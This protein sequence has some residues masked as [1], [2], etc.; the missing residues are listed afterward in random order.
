VT[1]KAQEFGMTLTL[2]GPAEVRK[3]LGGYTE[4]KDLKFFGS[5]QE[6]R[7]GAAA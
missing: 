3:V 4:T 2:V 1:T 6:A 7:A 5:L